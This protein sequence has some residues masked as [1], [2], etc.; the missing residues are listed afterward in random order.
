MV[1]IFQAAWLGIYEPF[2]AK[3]DLFIQFVVELCCRSR[4]RGLLTGF[5]NIIRIMKKKKHFMIHGS[6]FF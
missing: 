6:K 5:V 3:P 4:W 1:F 2:N